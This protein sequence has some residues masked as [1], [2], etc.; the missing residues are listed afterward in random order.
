MNTKSETHLKLKRLP[1]HEP[2]L[3]MLD[4]PPHVQGEDP[5]VLARRRAAATN[6]LRRI[7]LPKPS[8]ACDVPKEISEK[9]R[10]KGDG[11]NELL[12][13]YMECGQDKV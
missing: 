4:G 2:T 10:L 11:R 12:D 13:T 3:L 8:G 9:F 1:M 6:Q 5:A 7:C